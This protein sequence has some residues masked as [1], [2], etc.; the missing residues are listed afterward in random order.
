[1]LLAAPCLVGALGALYAWYTQRNPPH[2]LIDFDQNYAAAHFLR[3]GRDPYQLIGPGREF[4][5]QW[6]LFYPLTTAVAAMPF[7]LLPMWLAPIV[8]GG[9][10]AAVFTI[11]LQRSAQRGAWRFL[12]LLS[13][14]FL[15]AVVTG[16]ASCLLASAFVLWPLA[17]LAAIK[18]NIGA[19]I[20][21]ARADRRGII[22][23][24]TGGAILLGISL[25][26]RPGWVAEWLSAVRSNPFRLPAIARPGGFLLLLSLLR[27]RRPEARLLFALAVVPQTLFIYDALPLF[28]IP[29]RATEAIALVVLSHFAFLMALNLPAVAD[30]NSRIIIVGNW[31]VGGLFLP[32]LALVLLRPNR[33]D[34]TIALRDPRSVNTAN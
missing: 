23:A 33:R 5:W 19:A 26:L 10:G 13:K 22:A 25:A 34:S 15:V 27:W 8:L 30:V 12:A 29:R 3:Q 32:C 14:P 4:D 11:A 31:V 17:S 18:P 28:F 9:I 7:T 1:M 24:V 6:P 20:V 16:Q 2:L 21:A